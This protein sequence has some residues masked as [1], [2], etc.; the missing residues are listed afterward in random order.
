MTINKNF[1]ASLTLYLE[2]DEVT[3]KPIILNLDFAK[4][5]EKERPR[6]KSA[7]GEKGGEKPHKIFIYYLF[8]DSYRG[9]NNRTRSPLLGSPS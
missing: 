5:R 1:G 6:R 8:I 4:T 9:E 2:N 3:C 7:S